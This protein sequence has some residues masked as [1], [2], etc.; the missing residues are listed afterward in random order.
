MTSQ[1]SPFNKKPQAQSATVIIEKT[2]FMFDVHFYSLPSHSM[3]CFIFMAWYLCHICEGAMGDFDFYI[4]LEH[5]LYLEDDFPQV[6]YKFHLW[7]QKYVLCSINVFLCLLL[8]ILRC[9]NNLC[10]LTNSCWLRCRPLTLALNLSLCVL[11]F[12]CTLAQVSTALT[13]S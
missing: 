10:A 7:K 4:L 8:C 1:K 11:N 6:I 12:A 3:T 5:K 13:N 2:I 9:N